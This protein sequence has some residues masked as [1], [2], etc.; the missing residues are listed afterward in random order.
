MAGLG[1]D[2]IVDSED[3]ARWDKDD[4]M[5]FLWETQTLQKTDI[6]RNWK[7]VLGI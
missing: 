6:A 5:L 4:V 7:S 1:P 2:M 3:E